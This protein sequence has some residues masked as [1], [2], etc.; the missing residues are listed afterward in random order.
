MLPNQ[1]I[2]QFVLPNAQIIFTSPKRI[3]SLFKYKDKLL[4]LICS[5]VAYHCR[6]PGCHALHCTKTACNL[7]VCCREDLGI[8]NAGK[9][10]GRNL[11]VIGDHFLSLAMMC[12]RFMENS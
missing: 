6:C 11:S 5:S 8:N 10:I 3:S 4:S 1:E 2:V 7:V 9:K 12:P